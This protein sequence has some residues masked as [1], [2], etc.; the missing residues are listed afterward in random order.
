[1]TDADAT[2]ETSGSDQDLGYADAVAE[3]DRILRELEGSD[4]DVDRLAERVAR[5]SELITLCRERIT[6]AQVE[7]RRVT[8]DLN[9]AAD[10]ADD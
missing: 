10:V 7:I 8:T 3:L 1:M 4:V 6:N 2:T 5:A 9:A